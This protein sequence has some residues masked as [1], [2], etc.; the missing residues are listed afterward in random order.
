MEKEDL[1]VFVMMRAAEPR[2][3]NIISTELWDTFY[4]TLTRDMPI[5]SPVN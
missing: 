4:D 3:L 1:V 2:L 5:V